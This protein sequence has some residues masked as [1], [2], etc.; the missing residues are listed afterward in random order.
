MKELLLLIIYYAFW[1][2]KYLD[3]KLIFFSSSDKEIGL[4]MLNFS[5][6]LYTSSNVLVDF[7]VKFCNTSLDITFIFF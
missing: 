2:I 7:N 3:K 1:K 5:I 4:C 6:L